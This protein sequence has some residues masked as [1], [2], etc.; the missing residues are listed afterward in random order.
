MWLKY[1]GRARQSERVSSVR[2]FQVVVQA[3]LA[4]IERAADGGWYESVSSALSRG[5]DGRD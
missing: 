5:T 4:A 1:N 2:L 3:S